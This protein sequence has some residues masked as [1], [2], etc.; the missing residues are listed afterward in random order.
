MNFVEYREMSN[1][2]ESYWWHTGRMNIIDKQL[3]RLF[4][5]E[6]NLNILNIGCGT[7]GTIKTLEKYGNVTNVDISSEALKLLKTKGYSGKLVKDHKLPFKDG[8][9]DLV[10]ALDVL[11]HINQ[12]RLSLDEWRRVLKNDGKALITVPAYE[13]LWSGHDISLHHQRRYTRGRLVWDL[14]KSSFEA[15]K[16]SYMI[17]FSF[18]LVV[19]FRML[20]KI[21]KKQM[22]ENTSYV[23]VPSFVN[24]IFYLILRVEGTLL[25][26]IDMPFGTSVLGVFIKQK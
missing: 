2:E 23:N 12:D 21:T 14:K 10:I 11:E 1:R 20:Y 26:Y 9:F 17:T 16:S 4:G 18:F 15:I 13:F 24:S 22:T 3:D 7:G 6:I 5:D 8:T 19:G 25:K